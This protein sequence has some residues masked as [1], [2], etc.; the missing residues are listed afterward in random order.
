MEAKYQP[1]VR[2]LFQA[3]DGIDIIVGGLEFD[4][5]AGGV[6]ETRLSGD[7]KFL[8]IGR[9]TVRHGLNLTAKIH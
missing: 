4:K 7:P 6:D 5:T 1:E 2:V 9:T 3:S 8:F